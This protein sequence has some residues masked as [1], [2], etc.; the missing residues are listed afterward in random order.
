VLLLIAAITLLNAFHKHTVPQGRIQP[1]TII[2][3][4]HAAIQLVQNLLAKRQLFI[5][6]FV[7]NKK[8]KRELNLIFTPLFMKIVSLIEMGLQT[9]P[10]R[11]TLLDLFHTPGSRWLHSLKPSVPPDKVNDIDPVNDLFRERRSKKQVAQAQKV[12]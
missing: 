8:K 5:R 3:N 2:G 4:L 11:R 1:T 10:I 9:M 7:G 6:V 12:F